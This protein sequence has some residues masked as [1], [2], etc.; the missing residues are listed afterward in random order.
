MDATYYLYYCSFILSTEFSNYLTSEKLKYYTD[1]NII[2]KTRIDNKERIK[3][4]DINIE[5]YYNPDLMYFNIDR[6]IN[7]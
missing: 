5:L 3:Y 6:I 7:F 4:K 2:Y 1:Q